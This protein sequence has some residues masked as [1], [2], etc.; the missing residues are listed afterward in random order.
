M[1]KFFAL[2]ISLLASI[3]ALAAD[4]ELSFSDPYIDESPN[5]QPTV[6]GRAEGARLSLLA[7][8]SAALSSTTQPKLYW[9]ATAEISS[10]TFSIQCAGDAKPIWTLKQSKQSAGFHVLDLTKLNVQLPVQQRCVW[11]AELPTVGNRTRKASA[12]LMVRPIGGAGSKTLQQLAA[13]GYW[14]DLIDAV[15]EK[16]QSKAAGSFALR[17][18]LLRQAGLQDAAAQ[19]ETHFP[20][21]V[22]AKLAKQILKNGEPI[23]LTLQSNKPAFIRWVYLD[24]RGKQTLILPNSYQ[25]EDVLAPYHPVK[26]PSATAEWALHVQAPFGQEQMKIYAS[27]QPLEP[28][29]LVSTG[30]ATWREQDKARLPVGVIE[31]VLPFESKQ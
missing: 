10:L 28:I 17:A 8:S 13:T 12:A 11:E 23:A 19:D 6:G 4:P 9:F 14:Y 1:L 20:L 7:P 30:F 25:R 2:S 22:T 15:S 29:S 27:E 5:L 3:S 18:R 31:I 21:E 16:T 26:Y 24:V